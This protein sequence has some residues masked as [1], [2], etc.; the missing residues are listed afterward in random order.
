[1]REN[2][3]CSSEG[4][5][6]GDRASLPYRRDPEFHSRMGQLCWGSTKL[7]LDWD[8]RTSERPNVAR[9]LPLDSVARGFKFLSRMGQPGWGATKLKLHRA[10]S[11]NGHAAI[12]VRG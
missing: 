12:D 4:G 2:R 6:P 10:V 9:L 11:Y 7:K 5:E 8:R 1:M 3:T